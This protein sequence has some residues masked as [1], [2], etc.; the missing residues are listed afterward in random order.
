L[1][2]VST[3]K[4]IRRFV[5]PDSSHAQPVALSPDGRT[6]VAADTEQGIIRFWDPGTGK[7]LYSLR[8][9]RAGIFARSAKR[10]RNAWARR[11]GGVSPPAPRLGKG[12]A[13]A[14]WADL[15]ETDARQAYRAIWTLAR[16][17]RHAVPLLRAKLLPPV[18]PGPRRVARL[19]ADL[20]NDR[21]AVRRQASAALR[22]LGE[23]ARGALKRALQ[24]TRSHEVRWRVGVLLKRLE[25][26]PPSWE[27]I[28]ER[29]AVEG[30]ERMGTPQ[31]RAL[32]RRLAR[33]VPG[34]VLTEEARATLKRLT[35]R[36]TAKP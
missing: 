31:A 24:T 26:L 33:G 28:R 29:R 7:E 30:L 17:P 27:R 6:L 2:D 4:E 22:K 15:A 12:E 16:S 23:R 8:Q 14:L 20:D 18:G 35:Q 32:L 34:A 10:G 13:E 3:G 21:Y 1:W 11:G 9:R 25:R 36:P 5:A 19:I